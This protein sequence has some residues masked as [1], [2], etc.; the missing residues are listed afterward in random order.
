M[1]DLLPL[2]RFGRAAENAEKQGRN[3]LLHF[4]YFLRSGAMTGVNRDSRAGSKNGINAKNTLS[5]LSLFPSPYAPEGTRP[6]V[7]GQNR[8]TDM[9]RNREA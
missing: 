3:E 8:G 6:I 2:L 1:N 9:Y 7:L 4:L 5:L